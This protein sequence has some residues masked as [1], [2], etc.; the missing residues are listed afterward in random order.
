MQYSTGLRMD[1]A[2]LGGFLMLQSTAAAE[3]AEALRERGVATDSRGDALRFGPA[4][5]LS[6]RQLDDAMAALAEVARARL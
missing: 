6:D 4:P 5:Y 1:L 2:E 3:L